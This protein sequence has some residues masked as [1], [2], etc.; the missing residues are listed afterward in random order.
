MDKKEFSIDDLTKCCWSR[1][2]SVLAKCKSGTTETVSGGLKASNAHDRYWV[3]IISTIN[4]SAFGKVTRVG[5]QTIV[6]GAIS[7]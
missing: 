2:D 4:I 6:N 7:W 3:R 5:G 1:D